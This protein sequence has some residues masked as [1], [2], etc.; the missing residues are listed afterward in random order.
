MISRKDCTSH[1]AF[2]S[3]RKLGS[4]FHRLLLESRL[5]SCLALLSSVGFL[6]VLTYLHGEKSKLVADS[7]DS[8]GE[9]YMEVFC[10]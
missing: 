3:Q 7:L 5:F 4:F 9:K 6:L 8:V 10:I 1:K 2:G